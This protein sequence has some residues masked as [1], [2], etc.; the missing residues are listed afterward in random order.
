[1]SGQATTMAELQTSLDARERISSGSSNRFEI[2]CR[3]LRFLLQI[4]TAGS[5]QIPFLFAVE[6]LLGSLPASYGQSKSQIW[7]QILAAE[8]AA[9]SSQTPFNL[10]DV[11]GIIYGSRE[12]HLVSN[13]LVQTG[14][15]GHTV[16]STDEYRYAALRAL[17][18]STRN[19]C[20]LAT[21]P[22][23]LKTMVL[24]EFELVSDVDRLWLP[25]WRIIEEA[26]AVFDEAV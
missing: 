21:L 16:L 4:Q 1:M 9:I 10:S 22:E 11:V 19:K 17:V 2:L 14:A 13:V 8:R 15:N 25:S 20:H 23:E 24:A 3:F 5:F 7:N 12:A 18:N 26:R 6:T